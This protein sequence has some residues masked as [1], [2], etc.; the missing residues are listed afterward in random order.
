MTV[1]AGLDVARFGDDM[2]G[3][4]VVEDTKIIALEEWSKRDLMETCGRVVNYLE[5]YPEVILAIDDTG[6]GGGVTDRLLELDLDQTILPI[7]YGQVA[8]EKDRFKDKASEMW[9]RVREIHDPRSDDPVEY[10]SMNP[11]VKRLM[12][13]LSA[14]KYKFDSRGRIWIIKAGEGD[15][16]P[17]LG[18]ALALAYEAWVTFW[19]S[20]VTSLRQVGS[21]M[22]DHLRLERA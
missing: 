3:L 12:A 6:L 18:D 11:L 10:P 7:N 16:S 5:D 8:Y 13:Q 19:A 22:F 15:E 17:G 2:T 1:T 4:V 9:W 21:S 14:A 20:S